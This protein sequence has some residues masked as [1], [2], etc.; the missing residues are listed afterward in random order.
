MKPLTFEMKKRILIV[1]DEPGIT[2]G[3]GDQLEMEG[4]DVV[5]CGD[6][7]SALSALREQYPDLMVLDVMLPRLDGFQV[8]RTARQLGHR[9]PIIMLTARGEEVDKVLGL[10]FG[11][12]DYV[13][14]PFSLREL[15]ARIKAVLRRFEDNQERGKTSVLEFGDVVLDFKAYEAWKSGRP[16]ELTPREFRVM[17]VFAERPRE[18]ISRDEFLDAAWGENIHVTNRS[19]DNQILNLRRKLEDDPERPRFIVSIRSVGYK[20]LPEGET[21]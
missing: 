18:V 2:L 4:F 16:V 15:V 11:A 14:K 1:D 7:E 10:E 20:F 8:C 17:K 3:L 13:T 6:G 19:V 9:V 21:S 5:T 12:D